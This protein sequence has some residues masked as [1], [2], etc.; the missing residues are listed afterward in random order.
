M[1]FMRHIWLNRL[2][3]MPFPSTHYLQSC[4]FVCFLICTAICMF[5]HLS[6]Y[7]SLRVYLSL[8]LSYSI[9][10]SLSLHPVSLS[11]SILVC[12]YVCLSFCLSVAPLISV[13]L[14][15]SSSSVSLSLSFCVVLLHV[16][17]NNTEIL[18]IDTKYFYWLYI[19]KCVQ[20]KFVTIP[21]ETYYIWNNAL[22]YN[23]SGFLS[24]KSSIC[25][26]SLKMSSHTLSANLLTTSLYGFPTDL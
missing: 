5:V 12:L 9:S 14:F 25:A 2:L 7:V 10:M 20:I 19:Q 4:L 24:K 3:S 11:V 16:Y 13:C 8:S 6:F 17:N 18:Y 21:V 23:I 15:L 22:K 26:P 1:I